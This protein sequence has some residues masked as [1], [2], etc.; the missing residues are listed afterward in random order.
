METGIFQYVW[1]IPCLIKTTI[2][3]ESKILTEH[4]TNLLTEDNRLC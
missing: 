4:I 3:I 1:N 2:E